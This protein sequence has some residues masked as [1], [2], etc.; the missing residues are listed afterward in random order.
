MLAR[1]IFATKTDILPWPSLK[2]ANK[3]YIMVIDSFKWSCQG[4]ESYE[5]DC[6]SKKHNLLKANMNYTDHCSTKCLAWLLAF[7][8]I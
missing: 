3:F 6:F 7:L 5:L 8:K 2:G 1:A 4:L